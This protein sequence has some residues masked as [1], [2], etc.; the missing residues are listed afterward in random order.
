[1]NTRRAPARRGEE[2]VVNEGV[3]SRG[4]QVPIDNQ[5]NVNEKV[6][7]KFPKVLNLPMLKGVYLMWI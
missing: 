7:L 6:P 4:E 5:D 2:R 1:M 3:L